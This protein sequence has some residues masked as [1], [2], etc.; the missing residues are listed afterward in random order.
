MRKSK[1]L[2]NLSP[3]ISGWIFC[4]NILVHPQPSGMDRTGHGPGITKNEKVRWVFAWDLGW[5]HSSAPRPHPKSPTDPSKAWVLKN[6]QRLPKIIKIPQEL[7][8]PQQTSRCQKKHQKN[9]PTWI[10]SFEILLAAGQLF[11][12]CIWSACSW[13]GS[14]W[15]FRKRFPIPVTRRSILGIHHH[16]LTTDYW[17]CKE[18]IPRYSR[19]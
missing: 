15:A 16:E 12:T 4:S 8:T 2:Y 9:Q 6:T 1:W 11:W 19:Y 5:K 17:N 10:H 18:G 3:N 14:T 7:R 13:I